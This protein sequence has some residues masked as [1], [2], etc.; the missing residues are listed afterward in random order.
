VALVA[1]LQQFVFTELPGDV[2]FA[3]VPV[4]WPQP[5]L[6]LSGLLVAR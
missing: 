2:G 4:W 3:T 5:L 1:W 6:T